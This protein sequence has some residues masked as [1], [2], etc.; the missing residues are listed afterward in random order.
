ML[1]SRGGHDPVVELLLEAGT[2]WNAFD[3]EGHCAGDL[4]M[5]A[6]HQ[7]TIDLLLEAGPSFTMHLSPVPCLA[8]DSERTKMHLLGRL[9]GN[10]CYWTASS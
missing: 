2:P 7:S 4:A 3:K 6:G 8:V 9:Q 5:M 10:P 1:A